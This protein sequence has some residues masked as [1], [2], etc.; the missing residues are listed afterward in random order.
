MRVLRAIYCTLILLTLAA[1]T[2]NFTGYYD[3]A[4][5]QGVT[6]FQRCIDL[7]LIQLQESPQAPFRQGFYD[8]A[9]TELHVLKTRASSIQGDDKTDSLLGVLEYQVE[10]IVALDSG[11]LGT[12]RAYVIAETTI[13]NDCRRT[14]T[15]ELAK[16][17]P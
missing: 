10:Q 6:Q 9:R 14:L 3:Q 15:L 17:K 11:R 2:V 4:I 12:T 7:H 16:K 8:S 13:D 1:C 5:D